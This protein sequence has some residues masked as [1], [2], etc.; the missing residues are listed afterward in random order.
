MLDSSRI[1]HGTKIYN[2]CFSVSLDS[3]NEVLRFE[4]IRMA[5]EPRQQN[6]VIHVIALEFQTWLNTEIEEVY[7]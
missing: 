2:T 6:T 5:R 7:T 3:Q 1:F 4:V